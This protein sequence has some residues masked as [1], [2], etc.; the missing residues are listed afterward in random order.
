MSA[1]VLFSYNST[2]HGCFPPTNVITNI[3]GSVKINGI[4]ISVVGDRYSPHSCGKT[5]HSGD[6]RA[7]IQGSGS[8]FAG[9]L[10]VCRIGDPIACGDHAGQ[11]SVNVFAGG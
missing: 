1:V 2:G 9:G 11:G 3:V 5:V 4:S 7:L 8:V 10:N 6:S